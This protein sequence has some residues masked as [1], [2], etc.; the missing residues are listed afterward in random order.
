MSIRSGDPGRA[1]VGG[2]YELGPL[3][4][5]GGMG[6]VYRAIDTVLERPVA[7]KILR[8][9]SSEGDGSL[10]RFEREARA[11]AMLDHPGFVTV[12]DVVQ[13]ERGPSIVMELI[14]GVSVERSLRDEGPFGP[15][16]AVTIARAVADAIA[17]AHRAGVVHRDL[18][19]GNVMVSAAGEVKVLDF[20]I[21]RVKALTPLT[22]DRVVQGTA[23]YISPEQARGEAL[24]GRSDIYSL[25]IVLYEM[26]VGRPPFD[27][28]GPVAVMYKHLEEPPSLPLG[29][30]PA[31]QRIILRCLAK[32][33]ADRFDH[34]EDLARALDDFMAGDST[35]PTKQNRLIAFRVTRSMSRGGGTDR[36]PRFAS[37]RGARVEPRGR[38]IALTA[39]GLGAAVALGAF[40]PSLLTKGD[41]A[42][43]GPRLPIL[44]PPTG[45]DVTSECGGFVSADVVLTWLPSKS[46]AAVGYSVYRSM[47]GGPYEK[48]GVME[49][50]TA[51]LFRDEDLDT[52]TSYHYRVRSTAGARASDYSQTAAIGTPV[53]CMW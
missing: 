41:T 45:L 2:R 33:P 11:V 4:G 32:D 36:L 44:T 46:P 24:D 23:E 31:L 17:A 39:L 10:I 34:A 6:D 42:E 1:L 18:K 49:G 35:A 52:G 50:P 14:E 25:G 7:V 15:E 53:L 37:R 3:M 21:A 12:Y 5:R 19:P 8:R 20:G 13:D 27:A 40:L 47:E 29:T 16:R 9:A 26:L 30:D 51:T 28:D 43:A 22:S 38:R 48:V